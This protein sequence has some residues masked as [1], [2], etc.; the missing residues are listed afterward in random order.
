[1]SEFDKDL[2]KLR[3]LCKDKFRSFE[4]LW[5]VFPAKDDE[6]ITEEMFKTFI[7]TKVT[8]ISFSDIQIIK[9]FQYLD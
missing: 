9:F 1:M 8:K 4:D 2:R 5:K 3:K 7:K 6:E